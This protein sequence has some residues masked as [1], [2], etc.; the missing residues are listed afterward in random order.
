MHAQYKYMAT[1]PK[2]LHPWPPEQQ[3]ERRRTVIGLGDL[4]ATINPTTFRSVSP[5]RMGLQVGVR[6]R[7]C[8]QCMSVYEC[9]LQTFTL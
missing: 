3:Q 1:M 2:A 9:S 7:G 5:S 6:V 8:R 4:S